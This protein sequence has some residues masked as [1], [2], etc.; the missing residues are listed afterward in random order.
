MSSAA[1]AGLEPGLADVV[2]ACCVELARA[3]AATGFEEDA[4]PEEDA[5]APG[6]AAAA[7]EARPLRS[8]SP[9]LARASRR[10]SDSAVRVLGAIRLQRLR[11]GLVRGR[12]RGGGGGDAAAKILR[13][14]RE[15]FEDR[16]ADGSGAVPEGTRPRA[17]NVL[18]RAHAASAA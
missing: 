10:R 17:L 7:L 18:A 4:G 9:P 16:R 15:T 8:A 14:S 13:F 12:V 2:G 6:D 5:S 3:L 11:I 1:V